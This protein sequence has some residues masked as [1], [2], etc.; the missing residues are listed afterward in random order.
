MKDKII[1][2]GTGS[3]AEVVYYYFEH[4]SNYKVIAFCADS[5]YINKSKFLNLPLVSFEKIE[6]KYPPSKY[7]MFIAVGY[8]KNNKIRSQIF[9]KIKRKGYKLISYIYPSVKIWPN[10]KIGENT[11]IFENN[12]IQPFVEIGNN[13]ILWSGNH[14][15]HH[16]KIED[17]CFITSHVVISGNCRVG[18]HV[19][20]GV[21]ATLRNNISIGN[22]CIIG[23]GSLI[24]KSTKNKELYVAPK[25]VRDPRSVDQINL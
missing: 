19:F 11:F 16:S 14:I 13:V 10:N 5:S 12:T 15:G 2:F 9:Y 7:K 22:H 20:I 25:T 1:I 17:H 6:K 18:N 3:F 24:M 21:N 8:K 4:E 23:A